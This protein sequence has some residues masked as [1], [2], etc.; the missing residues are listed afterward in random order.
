MHTIKPTMNLK[1][2]IY[3]EIKNNLENGMLVS[4]ECNNYVYQ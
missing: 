1:K 4:M 2:E 3:R